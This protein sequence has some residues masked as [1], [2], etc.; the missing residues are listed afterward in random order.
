MT[1]ILLGQGDL[2]ALLDRNPQVEIDLMSGAVPQLAGVLMKKI[3]EKGGKLDDLVR[4]RVQV[5]MNEINYRGLPPAIN[6]KIEEAGRKAV[7]DAI[8]ATARDEYFERLRQM[9]KQ[10]ND[11]CLKT[12]SAQIDQ[13]VTESVARIEAHVKATAEREV[14]ALIRGL[15]AVPSS[16]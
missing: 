10:E 13:R 16:G 8:P 1:K 12:L 11:H 15:G 3:E 9:V 14:L 4:Q 7:K 5:A 2:A 6:A